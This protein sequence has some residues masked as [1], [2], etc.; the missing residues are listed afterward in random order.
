VGDLSLGK[1]LMDG[2]RE[3]FSR[4]GI[5]V[6]TQ[7]PGPFFSAYLTEAPIE[8]YRDVFVLDDE[9]YQRFWIGLLERGVRILGTSRALWLLSAAHTTE[10]VEITLERVDEVAAGLKK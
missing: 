4:H 7:G 3:V 9:L 6:T 8:T 5:P 1:Q 2:L 10:D